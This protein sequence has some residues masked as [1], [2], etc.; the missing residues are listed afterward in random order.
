M[1]ALENDKLKVLTFFLHEHG[2]DN[3]DEKVDT[4]VKFISTF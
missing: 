1:T 3:V 4:N 2:T